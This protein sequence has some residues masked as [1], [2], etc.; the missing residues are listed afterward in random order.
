[1][2]NH[3]GALPFHKLMLTPPSGVNIVAA[4]GSSGGNFE[5]GPRVIVWPTPIPTGCI[6]QINTTVDV[7]MLTTTVAYT[8]VTKIQKQ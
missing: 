1:M 6:E 8:F 3:D 5:P 7:L 2:V 4:S